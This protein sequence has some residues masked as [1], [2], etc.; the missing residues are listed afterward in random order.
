[1]PGLPVCGRPIVQS[2]VKLHPTDVLVV[3]DNS[4]DKPV[5]KLIAVEWLVP[6]RASEPFRAFALVA[7]FQ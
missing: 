7:V 5:G 4:C 6:R 3:A 2:I 1:M